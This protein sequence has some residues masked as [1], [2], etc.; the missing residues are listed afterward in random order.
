MDQRLPG[1]EYFGEEVARGKEGSALMTVVTEVIA[2]VDVA[3]EAAVTG[4]NEHSVG[5][6]QICSEAGNRQN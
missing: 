2:T 5:V 6:S 4:K 3:V 1:E